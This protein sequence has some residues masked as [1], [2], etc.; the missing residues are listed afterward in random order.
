MP[1]TAQAR[2]TKLPVNNLPMHD[3]VQRLASILSD[4]EKAEKNKAEKKL[5][6]SLKVDKHL[7]NSTQKTQVLL[8]YSKKCRQRLLLRNLSIIF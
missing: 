7:D 3:I 5:L 2:S 8:Q 6:G 4:K 1:S